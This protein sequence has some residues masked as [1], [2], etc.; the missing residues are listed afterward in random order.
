MQ[1]H[2]LT[3]APHQLIGKQR[4]RPDKDAFDQHAGNGKAVVHPAH[5]G[6]AVGAAVG[7]GRDDGQLHKAG[8]HG[9]DG[10]TGH[11]QPGE[12]AKAENQQGVKDKVHDHRQHTGFHRQHGL[13][14]LAQ[15]AGVALGQAEGHQSHKHDAQ[16]PPRIV[17]RG[18]GIGGGGIG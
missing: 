12:R 6:V 13:A 9:G 10:R 3:C 2:G 8:K 16:I 17:Q 11:A 1:Q 5:K 15:G 4:H 14:A 7:A 18:G